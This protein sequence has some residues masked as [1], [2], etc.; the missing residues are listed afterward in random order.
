MRSAT[1]AA[2]A[3]IPAARPRTATAGRRVP[4]RPVRRS[5][6][7]TAADRGHGARP[8]RPLRL[9]PRGGGIGT[10]RAARHASGGHR[11]TDAAARRR[12][13]HKNAGAGAG[14]G[15]ST[16][17][18]ASSSAWAP[19]SSRTVDAAW[20]AV[21]RV[22]RRP[23]VSDES[24]WGYSSNVTRTSLA[25]LRRVGY[26]RLSSSTGMVRTPAVWRAYSAKPG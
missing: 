7:G 22:R 12:P 2:G 10:R 24:M 3:R 25:G 14:S 16:A 26:A 9:A 18:S 4:R 17:S 1:Q 6:R 5:R 23:T 15:L 20:R 21:W 13:T 8:A 19:S 11:R